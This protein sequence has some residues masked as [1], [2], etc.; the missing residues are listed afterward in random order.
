LL[1]AT[2]DRRLAHVLGVE[3][4]A[5]VLARHWELDTPRLLLAALLHDVAKFWPKARQRA[6]LD[7]PGHPAASPEDQDFPSIWHGFAA[8]RHAREAFGIDDADVLDAVAFHPTGAPGLSPLGLALYVAD[9]IE[10]SRDWPGAPAFRREALNGASLEQVALR[11]A[12]H[13]MEHL[14]ERSKPVHPRSL[15]MAEQLQARL[16]R[17]N[18]APE[19]SPS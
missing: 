11:V 10:P 9:F 3:G 17:P 1:A 12:L 14:R 4:M 18:P 2:P 7:E 5:V 15:R 13:K 19:G 6:A 16:N 8:A